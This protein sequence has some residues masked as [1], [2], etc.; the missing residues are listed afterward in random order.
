LK[1][2]A[3]M[4]LLSN[5][6]WM[7]ALSDEL[8]N[9][10]EIPPAGF[11]PTWIEVSWAALE[12]NLVV[13][14]RHLPAGCAVLPVVKDN[15]YGHGLCPVAHWLEGRVEMLAVAILEEAVILCR[16]G[17]R[18]TVLVLGGL[19]PGQEE[20]ALQENIVPVIFNLEGLCRWE[21][22]ASRRGQPAAFH[23]KVDTGM[24]RLGVLPEQLDEFLARA[25]A[26][27]YAVC[28]GLMTHL[29][30]ADLLNNPMTEIQLR[31]FSSCRERVFHAGLRPRWIHV[32]NSAGILDHPL[33]H[34]NLVR[35]GIAF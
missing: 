5:P 1:W 27:R 24:N 15:A 7:A 34:F 26:C 6:A 30:S 17:I 4:S 25:V 14:Q 29:A 10:K 33:T 21:E 11:R 12:N 16:S 31:T 13:L 9:V 35:P 22:A 19:A 18:K 20:P 23:M 3:T 32:A 8:I 28:E 2:F